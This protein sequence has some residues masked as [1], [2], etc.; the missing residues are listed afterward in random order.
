LIYY[1]TDS[2]VTIAMAMPIMSSWGESA[3]LTRRD[4]PK[5]LY[6]YEISGLNCLFQYIDID[7]IA[8]IV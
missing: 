3:K 4:F 7:E 8:A 5:T 6:S 1:G 2:P